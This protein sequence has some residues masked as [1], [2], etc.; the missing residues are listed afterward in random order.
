MTNRRYF[1]LKA[2]ITFATK[3]TKRERRNFQKKSKDS[4]LTSDEASSGGGGSAST[5]LKVNSEDV[6]ATDDQISGAPRSAVLQACTL[7]SGLLLAGGLL[8]RQVNAVVLQHPELFRIPDS[9]L[10]FLA[11]FHMI[12]M[13]DCLLQASHLASLNGWP[14]SDPTDVSCKFF[15]HLCE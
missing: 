14:I 5:S 13:T 1:I 10:F 3:S 6:A 7:T 9:L 15:F 8:L 2:V 11:E 12:K 4:L